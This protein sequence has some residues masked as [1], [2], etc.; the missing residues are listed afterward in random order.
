MVHNTG[1]TMT[2]APTPAHKLL[3][4][5]HVPGWI[6]VHLFFVLSGFLITGILIDSKATASRGEYFRGFYVRRTLRIFPLYYAALI[7]GFVIAPRVL[8]GV[9]PAPPHQQL[10]YWTYLS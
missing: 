2:G 6:G 1:T 9:A 3:Y 5:L 4:A 8:P 10:W 7:A